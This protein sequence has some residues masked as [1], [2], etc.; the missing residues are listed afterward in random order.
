M[1]LSLEITQL[2][3]LVQEVMNIFALTLTILIW[4]RNLLF[5]YWTD[6]KYSHFFCPWKGFECPTILLG[7]LMS[8]HVRPPPDQSL[9]QPQEWPVLLFFC[10]CK[11]TCLVV[12]SPSRPWRR[13]IDIF[14]APT[15]T[16]WALKSYSVN[17]VLTC[18]QS[19]F[20]MLTV[21]FQ[22]FVDLFTSTWRLRM[23]V[24]PGDHV[25][26][27]RWP[28]WEPPWPR[29]WLLACGSLARRWETSP[30]TGGGF[31][32]SSSDAGRIVRKDKSG[33]LILH[34]R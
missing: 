8:R 5:E 32:L 17:M 25:C 31:K 29:E 22:Y 13:Y 15:M 20:S 1:L 19:N 24:C 10:S 12:R 2:V 3:P 27:S 21:V 4:M 18:L 33:C 34:E 30:C 7:F 16:L 6:G 11:P 9:P 26:P 28:P 14:L 23:N